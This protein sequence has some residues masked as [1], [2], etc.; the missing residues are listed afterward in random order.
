MTLCHCG[1]CTGQVLHA[2]DCGHFGIGN[3]T[4]G[5]TGRWL[6]ARADAFN[7]KHPEYANFMRRPEQEWPLPR[8]DA[9]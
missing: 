8:K 3:C 6:D 9:P 1:R 4:C 2:P 5:A 7:A